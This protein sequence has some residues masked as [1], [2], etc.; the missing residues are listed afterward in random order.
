MKLIYVANIRLPSERAHVIQVMKMCEA[1]AVLGNSVELLVPDKRSKYSRIGAK[2]DLFAYFGVKPLFAVTRLGRRHYSESRLGSFFSFLQFIALALAHVRKTKPDVIYS[3]D[4]SIV[5]AFSFFAKNLVWETHGWKRN[6]RVARIECRL[7]KVV[8]ITEA[9]KRRYVDDGLASANILVAP[10]GVD[11]SFFASADKSEARRELGLPAHAKI[12]MYTGLLDEWKGY[13]TLLAAS[14]RLAVSGISVVI[15]GGTDEQVE[16]LRKAHPDV[17]FTGFI[18]YRR[19]PLVQAAADVLVIPNSATSVVS[20]E[21]TS[22]LK[23]FAHM[24][25]ERPIVASD[26]ASLREVLDDTSA[27]FFAPDDPE[28]LAR[29]VLLALSDTDGASRR[30]RRAKELVRRY[31]WE[32]RAGS[33]LAFIRK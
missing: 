4:E 12:V 8:A 19:L 28:A 10:D 27:Y 24:T 17:I 6:F 23:L 29:A 21:Y 9:A 16:R 15:V 11:D 20:A 30:A 13:K 3:R 33:I 18:P 2:E 14:P 22:P 1:F 32:E 7:K 5:Y 25:A 31:T 26:L